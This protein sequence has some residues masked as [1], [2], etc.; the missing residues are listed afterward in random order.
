MPAKG[1]GMGKAGGATA[2][3]G[4]GACGY[5]CE[6]VAA[7]RQSRVTPWAIEGKA[8]AYSKHN[9]HASKKGA[10]RGAAHVTSGRVQTTDGVHAGQRTTAKLTKEDQA[11]GAD[12]FRGTNTN[13]Y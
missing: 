8:L 2:M 6:Y 13:H 4:G 7:Q 9:G 1:A 5:S 11:G 10:M 12:G 3:G